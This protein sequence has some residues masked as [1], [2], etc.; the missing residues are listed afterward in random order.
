MPMTN[1]HTR[2]RFFQRRCFQPDRRGSLYV[3]VLGVAMI[4]SMIGMS[5]MVV[6]RLNLRSVSW[7]QDRS[8]ARLLADSA[9][10]LG[11]AIVLQDSNWRNDFLNGQEYPSPPMTIGNGTIAWK[12]VDENDSNL[13]DDDSDVT[14]LYGIGRVGQAVYTKS[15]RMEPLGALDSLTSALHANDKLWINNSSSVITATGG[16]VSTN[17]TAKNWGTINGDLECDGLSPSGTVN[18]TTTIPLDPDK[19]MPGPNVF[20]YYLT[21]GT[22]IDINDIPLST[23]RRLIEKIVLSPGNNPYGSGI[24]N[25]EGIYVIDCKNQD[26]RIKLVRLV[27]TLVLLNPGSGSDVDNDQHWEPAAPNFPVLMVQGDMTFNW[28]G[29][30]TLRESMAGVNYNPPHTPYQDQSDADQSD[31]YPGLIKGLVYVAGNLT[32]NH[33]C[34]MEGVTVIGGYLSMSGVTM[35][36][37][38][39][40]VFLYNPPP[41]F[42]TAGVDASNLLS[43]PGGE[44]GTISWYVEGTGNLATYFIN[45]HS[46]ARSI[47]INNRADYWSV[48]AQDI[49]AFVQNGATYDFTVWVWL[50][51]NQQITPQIVINSTGGGWQTFAPSSTAGNGWTWTHITSTIT[52]SWSGTLLHASVRVGTQTSQ[53]FWIDDAA[54]K[55]QGAPTQPTMQISPGSWRR[56]VSN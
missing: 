54:L 17:N 39:D 38:Y 22:L 15:V 10:E 41:G 2:A 26:I 23:G 24:T 48:P 6:A 53:E 52:P 18:G 34:V 16:P 36:L 19:T 30:H 3:S 5:T 32:V 55:E 1:S 14:R 43:N 28:H 33:G 4:V 21:H 56:E 31:E 51:A 35:D 27:G 25:P 40:P 49:T 42:R 8:E 29:E 9:V 37:T 11:A 45:P 13:A 46:G 50:W 12:L 7:R 47:F 44:S 20:D